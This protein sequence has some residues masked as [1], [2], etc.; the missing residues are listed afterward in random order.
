MKLRVAE[1]GKHGAFLVKMS[2]YVLLLCPQIAQGYEMLRTLHNLSLK[3]LF[4]LFARNI[5]KA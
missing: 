5:K 2:T 3:F 4:E 1:V